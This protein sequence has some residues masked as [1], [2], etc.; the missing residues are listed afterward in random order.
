M[1]GRRAGPPP[2][3]GESNGQPSLGAE[4]DVL[5]RATAPREC[6]LEGSRSLYLRTR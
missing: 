6:T 4:V 3:W 5:C 2:I 1:T